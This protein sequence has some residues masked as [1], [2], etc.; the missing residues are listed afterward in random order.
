[1][2][3]TAEK[4][5][6]HRMIKLRRH[7]PR[8]ISGDSNLLLM[9][10]PLRQLASSVKPIERSRF[11]GPTNTKSGWSKWVQRLMKACAL[12]TRRLH[13]IDENGRAQAPINFY[14]FL[15]QT[16]DQ[17]DN[18]LR[19]SNIDILDVPRVAHEGQF[20]QHCIEQVRR[21]IA[22]LPSWR[23]GLGIPLAR[24]QR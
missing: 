1:M 22:D 6:K 13:H 15:V 17:R 9:M 24:R 23:N 19:R 7:E 2:R 20:A 11:S 21:H 14:A 4:A 16:I 3:Q 10:P 8:A 18:I 12:V 5:I